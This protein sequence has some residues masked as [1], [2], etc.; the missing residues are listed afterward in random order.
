MLS[1]SSIQS[2]MIIIRVIKQIVLQ[3]EGHAD[4][5]WRRTD[6]I[7]TKDEILVFCLEKYACNFFLKKLCVN[8]KYCLD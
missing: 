6:R 4:Y 2:L 5:L 1:V 7:E 8:E 3:F